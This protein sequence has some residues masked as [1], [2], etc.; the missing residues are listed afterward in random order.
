METKT[1]IGSGKQVAD[2][3]I[4]DVTLS[5]QQANAFIYEYEGKQ[6]L[7][8]SVSKRKEASTFGKTHAVTC[9]TPKPKA[10]AKKRKADKGE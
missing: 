2:M 6:Y 4:I 10:K 5:M 3:D 8:F 9:F 1:F 7:R